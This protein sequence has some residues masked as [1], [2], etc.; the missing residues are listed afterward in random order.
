MNFEQ[1]DL[2]V[3]E[4]YSEV[5]QLETYMAPQAAQVNLAKIWPVA[6]PVLQLVASI[7]FIPLKWR[8]TINTL[9][10]VVDQLVG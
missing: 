6:K 4:N 7:P 9:V 5:E 10:T 2:H 1:V 3:H 8:N